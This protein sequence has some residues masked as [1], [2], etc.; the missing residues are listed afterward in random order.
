MRKIKFNFKGVI[1]AIL[2]LIFVLA[3]FLFV[4]KYFTNKTES[5]DYT[6]LKREE[7]PTKIINMM[8]K[9]TDEERALVAKMG[10]KTYIMVTRGD[11]TSG[12]NLNKVEKYEKDGKKIVKVTASFNDKEESNPYIVAAIELDELP[13]RVELDMQSKDSGEEKEDTEEST[14]T[15]DVDNT[16][17]EQKDSNIQ[18]QD[19]DSNEIDSNVESGGK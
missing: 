5:I 12:I 3:G 19:T 9:Y 17:T 13:D 4:P 15:E 2:V 1:S 7:I 11:N 8:E 16:K 18:Q 10:E 6:I 14:D